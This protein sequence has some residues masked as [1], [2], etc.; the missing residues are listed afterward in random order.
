MKPCPIPGCLHKAEDSHLMCP[1]YWTRVPGP[2]QHQV[3]RHWR[4]VRRGDH[5]SVLAYTAA[6]AQAIRSVTPR[7]ACRTD[8]RKL[9]AGA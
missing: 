7:G 5:A 9:E 3:Q 4:G 6:K 1:S 8:L 2:I